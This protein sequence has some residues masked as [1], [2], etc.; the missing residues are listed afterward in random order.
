MR[1][2]FKQKGI[3]FKGNQ[4]P[5]LQHIKNFDS[6]K[7]E[8]SLL[9]KGDKNIEQH[10]GVILVANTEIASKE[11]ILSKGKNALKNVISEEKLTLHDNEGKFVVGNKTGI[12][13]DTSLYSIKHDDKMSEGNIAILEKKLNSFKLETQSLLDKRSDQLH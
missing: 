13:I 5:L 3:D 2:E 1:D 10:D 4:E 9:A 12:T 11:K 7:V 8:I 6:R